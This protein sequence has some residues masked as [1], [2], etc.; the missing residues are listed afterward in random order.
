[1]Q[2]DGSTNE[3]IP[4]PEDSPWHVEVRTAPAR[5][6]PPGAVDPIYRAAANEHATIEEL[7]DAVLDFKNVMKGLL[8]LT[9]FP[10][11]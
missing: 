5:N 3:I 4:A 11:K 1:M 9:P 8:D 2:L 6:Q 10:M 7:V